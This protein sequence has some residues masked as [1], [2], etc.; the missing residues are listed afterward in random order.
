MNERFHPISARGGI[1]QWSLTN[2][3]Q[4]L[5]IRKDSR[6]SSSA[7]ELILKIMDALSKVNR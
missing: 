5:F 4:F 7:T 6:K 1:G 2:K 3:G